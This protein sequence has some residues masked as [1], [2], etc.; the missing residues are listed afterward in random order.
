MGLDIGYKYLRVNVQAKINI[1]HRKP[2]I[3]VK[4]TRKTKLSRHTGPNILLVCSYRVFVFVVFIVEFLLSLLR[5]SSLC[6]YLYIH[7][8]L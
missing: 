4:T 6:A 3:L 1:A 2:I 5:G 8:K 7:K